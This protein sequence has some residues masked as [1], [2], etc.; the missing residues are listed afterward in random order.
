VVCS[1]APSKPPD[2]NTPGK[3]SIHGI[4]I[5]AVY[6]YP[7]AIA[8]SARD[9]SIENWAKSSAAVSKSVTKIAVA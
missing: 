2:V 3:V 6:R 7:L 5:S 4:A 1:P 9:R 8:K